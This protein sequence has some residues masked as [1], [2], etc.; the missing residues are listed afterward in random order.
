MAS[1]A[2]TKLFSEKAEA[3]S[4][5]RPKYPDEVIDFILKPFQHTNNFSAVDVGAGTGIASRI[6]AD[7]G[8][9]VTAVEPNLP[10]IES[11][12]PHPNVDFINASA[13]DFKMK[14]ESADLITVFQAFHWFNFKGSL[15]KF[16]KILKPDGRLSLIWSYWD[17]NDDFTG[18]YAE[19]IR[20]AAHNNDEKVTPYDGFEGL[21][22]RVR[23]KM[24]WKFQHLPYFRDVQ[25]FTFT[26][27]READLE[28]LIGDA[29]SQSY[30]IH[31]GRQWDDLQK[32]IERLYLRSNNP[33][34]VYSINV[35]SGQPK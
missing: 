18:E 17:T 27:T 6:L 1:Q 16:R 14:Y 19:L 31:E 5:Y 3:Y 33:R 22:K 26:H 2:A 21:V 29:R 34:L 9:K 23:M 24:L 30:L 20:T 7:R 11:A 4:K 28:M 13:E 12:E 8:I 32:K 10:M 15:K 25:R 35:F